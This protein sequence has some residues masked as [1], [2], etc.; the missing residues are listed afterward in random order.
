MLERMPPEVRD[1]LV[2]AAVASAAP[3]ITFLVQTEV[4]AQA[5]EQAHRLGWLFADPPVGSIPLTRLAVQVIER[6]YRQ[7][8]QR[9]R[10]A[11]VAKFERAPSRI[12]RESGPWLLSLMNATQLTRFV[13]QLEVVVAYVL[14]GM[15]EQLVAALRAFPTGSL[16][17]L[18]KDLDDPE[19][20]SREQVAAIFRKLGLNAKRRVPCFVTYASADAVDIKRF[21][22]ELEPQLRTSPD[23]DFD[24]RF[25]QPI[26]K[27]MRWQTEKVRALGESELGLM[28]ASPRALASDFVQ[29]EVEELRRRAPV[30]L[31]AVERTPSMDGL[32]LSQGRSFAEC[33]SVTARRAFTREL[34]G[35]MEQ[36]L[37]LAEQMPQVPHRLRGG[38]AELQQPSTTHQRRSEIGQMLA[39]AGDP[40]P[41]VG[42]IHGVLDI[43]WR[44]IPGGEVEITKQGRFRVEPFLM[45][46][47]PVTGAQFQAFVDAQDGYA[48]ARWW[49]DLQRQEVD[50]DALKVL[51]NHPVTRVTWYGATAFCRWLSERVGY[52]V[53]LPDEAERQWAAQ[54][55][56]AN[57]A[58]PWGAQWKRGAANTSEAEL[59]RTTAVGMYPGG[60]SRQ[61]V[62][63]LAGN[64]WEWCRNWYQNPLETGAAAEASRVLRGGS[65][66]LDRERARAGLRHF[67]LPHGRDSVIGFRVVCSSPIR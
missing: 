67:N 27:G 7:L 9:E 16:S 11:I 17:R 56:E 53:R 4:V 24:F 59:E 62:A 15:R 26:D 5:R 46:A 31:V 43:V 63:D 41:G 21:L 42:V 14:G 34:H 66:F 52:E 1:T 39:E 33:S 28:L 55:A 22:A 49:Q 47:Y 54:S 44:E 51:P 50:A 12:D 8:W 60:E 36:N 48:D 2:R 64:V 23:F 61:H 29:L 45:A 18:R 40:R 6:R 10:E 57:F 19:C 35:L 38:L 58:Y 25:H 13:S 32:F 65:W 37:K 20:R 3:P 30:I